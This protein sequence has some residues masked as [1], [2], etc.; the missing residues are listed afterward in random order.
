MDCIV[1]PDKDSNVRREGS[2][3]LVEQEKVK[4][5]QTGWN[6]RELMVFPQIARSE[7][8]E[9]HPVESKQCIGEALTIGPIV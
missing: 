5:F 8:R 9:F 4:R 2:L 3:I 6:E 1:F 7:W